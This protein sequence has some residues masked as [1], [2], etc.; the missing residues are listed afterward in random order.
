MGCQ[1]I[2]SRF[3]GKNTNITI[4]KNYKISGK[5]IKQLIN[6]QTKQTRQMLKI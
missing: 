3:S 5:C 6:L 2:F 1:N 4:G